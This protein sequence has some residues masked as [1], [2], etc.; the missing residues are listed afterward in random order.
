MPQLLKNTSVVIPC[1]NEEER[2]SH[3]GDLYEILSS[4]VLEIIFV[5]DGSSDGTGLAVFEL[6]EKHKLAN[7]RLISLG[8]NRGKGRAIAEGVAACEGS[9]VV[10]MDADLATDL[11][12]L[13]RLVNG[14]E[15]NDVVIG[16][17]TAIGH[18]VLDGPRHRAVM[19]R[20]FNRHVRRRTGLDFGDTQCGFKAFRSH[21]AR[22]L[23][24]ELRFPGY[25]FDIEILLRARFLELT[26]AEVPVTWTAVEGSHVRIIRDSIK[27]IRDV[28]AISRSDTLGVLNEVSSQRH[29]R[30][31]LG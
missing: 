14:L 13:T 19:G 29:M 24:Q 4:R 17:R 10:F 25:S 15:T 3:L 11:D 1:F 8:S 21:W 23:F 6:V 18:V 9:F 30:R 16:S 5:D 28:W 27:M 22:I 7:S 20:L 31:P 12:D 2:L 26:I